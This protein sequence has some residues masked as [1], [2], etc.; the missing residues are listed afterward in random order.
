MRWFNWYSTTYIR[1]LDFSH[2][3]QDILESLKQID[4]ISGLPLIIEH[5]CKASDGL[6]ITAGSQLNPALNLAIEINLLF[7]SPHLCQ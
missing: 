1:L 5:L 4:K 3:R 6:M 7:S 2:Q